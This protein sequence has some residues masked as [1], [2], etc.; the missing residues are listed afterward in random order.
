MLTKTFGIKLENEVYRDRE[1]VYAIIFNNEGNV[2]TVRTNKGNFLIGGGIKY[3]ENH[4]ECLK[5]ECI[6]ETGYDVEVKEF[7]C[8]ADKYCL[9]EDK[10]D[11]FHPIGYFYSANLKEKIKDPI[12]KNH[13]FEWISISD[14]NSKMYLEHQ[15]WA[16]EQAVLNRI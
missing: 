7:L 13:K 16:V 10:G 3:K 15:K 14:L 2:A 12:E 9:S 8:K 11:Y 4:E 6:E 1:G 5:R